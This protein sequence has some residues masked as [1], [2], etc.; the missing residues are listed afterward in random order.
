MTVLGRRTA[1]AVLFAV[2]ASVTA[3]PPAASAATVASPA[4]E[5]VVLT[6]NAQQRDYD[7]ARMQALT[8][9]IVQRTPI[10]P[11]AILVDEIVPTA[12]TAMRDQLNALVGPGTYAIKGTTSSVK[13]KVLLNTATMKFTGYRTWVD[14]CTTERSYQLVTANEISSG[15]PVAVAGVH[16]APSFNPGGSEEC[17]KLNAEEAR[18]QLAQYSDSGVLGDFNK[19]ATEAYYECN[20]QESFNV[21]PPQEWYQAMTT[22]SAIDGRTYHD[23]VRAAHLDKD[24]ATQWSWEDVA[25]ETL[26]D[27]STGFRRSRLDYIFASEQ[28]APIDAATDQGW[29]SANDDGPVCDPL[30]GCKYSDHR[31]LWARLGLSR[32]TTAPAAPAGV[33]A[34]AGDGQVLLKWSANATSDGVASYTVHREGA[35]VG[36]TTGTTLTETSLT[37]GTTYAYTVTATDAAGNQS[38]PSASASATPSA[39]PKL[40]VGDLDATSAK[41]KNGWTTMAAVTVQQTGETPAGGA[42]VAYTWST[43]ATG[44][45]VTPST[46]L[47]QVKSPILK[48]TLASVTLRVTNVTKSGF[49]YDPMLNHDPDGSSN[50]TTMAVTRP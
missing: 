30:P 43:G 25:T 38:A 8:N 19:R 32:D 16:F 31:F 17:K 14:V 6:I 39:P 45:C 12:L 46:G 33:S 3:S 2:V 5:I 48:S 15:R 7:A 47:C 21:S 41:V 10:L 42:T 20:P 1:A 37:N 29:T 9:G 49:S 11:D 22:Q 44:T 23:T 27:Q 34:T 4:G 50:G 35:V 18:R 36:T 13:V 26:C 40:H 24:M 28:M